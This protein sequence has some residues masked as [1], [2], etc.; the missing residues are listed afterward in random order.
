MYQELELLN[1][2]LFILTKRVC[3]L[4]CNLSN[5]VPLLETAGKRKLRRVGG[6]NHRLIRRGQGM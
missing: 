2:K 6:K 5:N 1:N 3:C 4:L